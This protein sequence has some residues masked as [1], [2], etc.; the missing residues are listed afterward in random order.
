VDWIA[1]WQFW[2]AFTLVAVVFATRAIMASVRKQKAL[3]IASLAE[4]LALSGYSAEQDI[5]IPADAP[6]WA[7]TLRRKKSMPA[8]CVKRRNARVFLFDHSI[9]DDGFLG[10]NEESSS[11]GDSGSTTTYRHT[12]AC[13][14]A[15]KLAIPAFQVI[16][17]LVDK[18]K[19]LVNQK[20]RGAEALGYTKTAGA[21]DLLIDLTSG[22]LA[23]EERPGALTL[24][25]Q[26]ELMAEYNIYG[27]DEAALGT[28]M[29]GPLRD[30]LLSQPGVILEAQ[31][32][33]LVVSFHVG[34]AFGHEPDKQTRLQRGLL[35]PERA[36]RLMKL[37][38]K[39]REALSLSPID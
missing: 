26:P 15:P 8:L 24:P 1:S 9:T 3:R 12:L 17:R 38:F 7:I 21:L 22:F 34:V 27:E 31:G 39:L 16:P 5:E 29:A 35:D 37:A 13:L 33:W 32:Q 6:D 11:S 14:Y 30:L 36:V 4:A 23:R 20:A 19:A 18:M 28:L 10:W 2:T 25:D